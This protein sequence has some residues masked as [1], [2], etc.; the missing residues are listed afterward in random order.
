[1]RYRCIVATLLVTVAAGVF[2]DAAD[3][4][5]VMSYNIHHAE[6]TDG[7]LDVDR[8]VDVIK[9]QDPDIVCLQEV[10]QG[11]GR[12]RGL[13]LP[14]LLSEKLD[15]RVV[16][17]PNIDHDGGK[18]GNATLTR[19]E[20]VANENVPL[21]TPEGKE[22]RGCLRTDLS[23]DGTV[24]A[25]FNTHLGLSAAERLPQAK[26]I[27][28]RLPHGPAIVCGD[29]NETVDGEG[30][31]LLLGRLTDS[32]EEITGK[33][34]AT[35]GQGNRAKRIDFVLV[36]A[37]LHVLSSHIVAGPEALVASDHL[38]FI[39]EIG[40]G[41]QPRTDIRRRDAETSTSCDIGQ[42]QPSEGI[43]E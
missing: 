38:P 22:Q 10:D 19:Y 17:G 13:D 27:F 16:Y 4:V 41:E 43:Q 31:R 39:A 25:V 14:A 18:Y 20:V 7:V 11:C 42:G 35:I 32:Y 26:A 37:R 8:I 15:M 29:L 5:R 21:L 24:V 34:T 28:D 30:V 23:I 2:A 12:T 6:G 9:G 40:V 33:P 1:M 36:S 3:T